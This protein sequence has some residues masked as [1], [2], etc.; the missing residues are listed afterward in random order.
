M[1]GE[2]REIARAALL[3]ALT[4][5]RQEEARLKVELLEDAKIKSVAVDYGGEFI[6]SVKSILERAL[7]AAR[8]EGVI[9]G[10]HVE[11]GA[12]VGATR[13]ALAQ[14]MPK[15]LG[16]NMGGKIGIA[17]RGDHVS[18]AIFVGI[19]LLHLDEVAVGLGHRAVY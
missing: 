14:I 7:V 8:R 6:S 4:R 5:E 15:A 2:S 12:V 18:V 11:E 9:S 10:G 1:T 17:R 16:L 3:M 19:G 13:E